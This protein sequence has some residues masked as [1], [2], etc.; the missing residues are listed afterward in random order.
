VIAKG[1]GGCSPVHMFDIHNRMLNMCS[2]GIS[3][4]E[5]FISARES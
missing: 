1:C 2:H 3:I 5:D 4:L